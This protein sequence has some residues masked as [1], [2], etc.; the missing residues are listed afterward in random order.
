[1]GPEYTC[2]LK[3]ALSRTNGF[4]YSLSIVELLIKQ[5][6][7][8]EVRLLAFLCLMFMLSLLCS[9]VVKVHAGGGI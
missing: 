9:T 4:N 6:Q 7:E 1:M 5:Q 8:D 3:I 2:Y